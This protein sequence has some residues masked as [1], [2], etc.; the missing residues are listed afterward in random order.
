MLLNSF[1]RA[2]ISRV[3][4]N[5][6]Y[7]YQAILVCLHILDRFN[8]LFTYIQDHQYSPLTTI[9]W[10]ICNILAAKKKNKWPMFSI[11]ITSPNRHWTTLYFAFFFLRK[12]VLKNTALCDVTKGNFLFH[13]NT[14]SQV[15]IHPLYIQSVVEAGRWNWVLKECAALWPSEGFYWELLH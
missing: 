14:Q 3:S 11:D 12:Y 5:K 7:N 10:H 9:F 1:S 6:R 13:S 4:W 2:H 15:F 8:F